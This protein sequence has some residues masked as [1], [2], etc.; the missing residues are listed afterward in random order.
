MSAKDIELHPISSE[1]ARRIVTA[2]HYSKKAVNNSQVHLGVFLRGKCGG[3]LQFGPPI[4]KDGLSGLLKDGRL[5]QVLELNRMAFADWLPRNSESRALAVAMRII[6]KAYPHVRAVVSF[7][8]G[9]QCGDGTIYRAAGFLLTDIRK[10]TALRRTKTGEVMHTISARW[11]GALEDFKELPPLPGYQ[12]RYIYMLRGTAADLTCSVLPFSAIDEAGARMYRGVARGKQSGAVPVHQTGEGGSIPTPALQPPPK[13]PNPDNG[14]GA[15][16][17]SP[18]E[19]FPASPDAAPPP[20][21]TCMSVEDT[22]LLFAPA[23]GEALTEH[24]R[25]PNFPPN[26]ALPLLV[27]PLGPEVDDLLRA[28]AGE[29]PIEPGRVT[30]HPAQALT[31][32]R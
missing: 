15:G 4:P 3:V 18:G 26:R 9:T 30:P 11:K 1:D 27:T 23:P 14:H 19:D 31:R 21:L 29:H 7:A 6:R 28:A 5:R 12:L 2:L 8:D 17:G 13:M 24:F 16:D 22:S 32:I 20:T 10:N 25:S